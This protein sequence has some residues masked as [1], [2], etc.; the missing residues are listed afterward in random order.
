[1]ELI[2][3]KHL[4]YSILLL[5]WS[6]FTLVAV[7]DSKE[8][9][10]QLN[11]ILAKNGTPQTGVEIYSLKHDQL[12]YA[13]NGNKL[14]TPASNTKLFT[15]V[16]ALHTL[17]KEYQFTTALVT[18]AE[19]TDGTITGDLYFKPDGDPSLS[20]LDVEEL[21]KKLASAGV[22]HITGNLY[23]VNQ[24]F[25]QECF[26]PGTTIDDLGESYFSPIG[27]CMIDRKAAIIHPNNHV[28]FTDSKSL[29]H[30]FFDVSSFLKNLFEKY[31]IKLDGE[32]MS[33]QKIPQAKDYHTLAEH[34][35]AKLGVLVAYL[36][37][38]SDNVYA[39]CL[40]KKIAAHKYVAPGT[41]PKARQALSEFL[42]DNVGLDFGEIKLVD[43][44][45]LSRYNLVSPHQVVLLLQWVYKQPDF[46]DFL[47]S[48]AIA[49]TD[50]T[51]KN[52]LSDLA[53][54][55]K[56]K[57]GTMGGVSALSGFIETED[58]LLAFSILNNG[59]IA[60]SLYN[61]PCKS[62]IEDSI[63]RLLFNEHGNS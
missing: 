12:V 32:I 38:E 41:W 51:L 60:T 34:K 39:D 35:S 33:V 55:V 57:T 59:Y 53:H 14:F 28:D 30:I 49:G 15:S 7:T 42:K 26:A 37:K 13:Y 50:G 46:T 1:M 58:D 31:G 52:R 27:S 16:C 8:L 17:G 45:G 29:E 43:G 2:K 19:I 44:S 5:A 3:T 63:C 24:E 54:K 56:A 40:F 62:E 36:L 47:N 22:A 4:Y 61:P 23:L 25:D 20:S 18:N 11:E 48:L 6:S 10:K 21:V 9:G